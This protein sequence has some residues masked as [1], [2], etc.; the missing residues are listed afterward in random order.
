[1][2]DKIISAEMPY[3]DGC[4][5]EMIKKF[6]L[7]R[8]QHSFHC[9]HNGVYIYQYLKPIVPV[10]Y[11]NEKAAK[12]IG[13]SCGTTALA[14]LLY[15]GGHMAH[16]LFRISVE[17]NNINIQS[18]IKYFSSHA[19]LICESVLIIW[20]ELPM[21]NKAILDCVDLLLKQICNKNEPFGRKPVIEIG[22][23]DK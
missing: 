8:Q 12:K 15:E 13:L 7:H 21:A 23:S 16:S 1:Q 2:I 22:D 9:L 3:K 4:L 11:I 5:K 10:T 18:T 19:D 17:E 14:A 6:M 20:N